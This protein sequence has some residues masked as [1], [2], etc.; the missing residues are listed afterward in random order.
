MFNTVNVQYETRNFGDGGIS[1]TGPNINCERQVV[2]PIMFERLMDQPVV[3][4]PTCTPLEVMFFMIFS[5]DQ[6]NPD[7]SGEKS[8]GLP[9]SNLYPFVTL[10]LRQRVSR[11]KYEEYRRFINGIYPVFLRQRNMELLFHHLPIPQLTSSDDKQCTNVSIWT[12]VSKLVG[13]A[14]TLRETCRHGKHM[15]VL[16]PQQ[17]TQGQGFSCQQH[18]DEGMM[19]IA[20]VW[21]QTSTSVL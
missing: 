5:L 13:T 2:P 6:T 21:H 11:P 14:F 17:T 8:S 10:Q 20:F 1:I 15:R 12:T 4:C 19:P 18:R 3:G 7:Q 9:H 16:V